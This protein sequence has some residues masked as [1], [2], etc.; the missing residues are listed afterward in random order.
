MLPLRLVIDTNVIVSAALKPESL[1]HT[2][3]LI[4]ITKPCR[5]YVS[6]PILEEYADVLSR[7]EL[8][9]RKGNRLQLIQLIK[10]HSHMVAPTR[11]LEVARDPDDNMFLECAD[12]AGADYLVTG[13]QKHFPAFWKKTKIITSR[14]FIG[15][16]AP[17]LIK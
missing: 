14:E 9:I 10:N 17:H 2:T 7:A 8:G 11:R 6:Q 12:A 13:N 3:F 16:A 4:A 1:Q 5:L 15:L